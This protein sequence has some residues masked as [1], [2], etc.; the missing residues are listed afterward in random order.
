M[1]TLTIDP[2][3]W[4][5]AH[6]VGRNPL[7]RRTDRLEALLLLVA[8]I[9]SLAMIPAAGIAGIEVFD[10]RDHQYARQAQARHPVMATVASVTHN[11][12]SESVVMHVRWAV[13]GGE[14][15][16]SFQQSVPLNAGQRVEIWTDRDGNLVRPPTPR[17][18][19]GVD[20]LV[21][22]V[23]IVLACGVAMASLVASVRSR[24]DRA[25]D[26]AWER[27]LAKVSEIG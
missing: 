7:L 23:L 13:A 27:E 4:R 25:R 6:L 17:W 16:G 3:R 26:A 15:T 21:T 20:A 10:A 19:A 12:N 1:E 24:L 9:A 8:L 5:I 14:R 18:H 11:P 2:R 22:S